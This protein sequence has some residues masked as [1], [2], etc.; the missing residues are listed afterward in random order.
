VNC[1][2][3][4]NKEKIVL[5]KQQEEQEEEEEEVKKG[6]GEEEKN[7]KREDCKIKTEEKE[8]SDDLEATERKVAVRPE[9]VDWK[10]QDKCYFCVDGKLIKVNELGELV[11]ETTAAVQPEAELNKHV[12]A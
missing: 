12:S 6:D 1:A 2:E 7:I 11:V 4:N 10:P 3:S 9:P 8:Q 5:E